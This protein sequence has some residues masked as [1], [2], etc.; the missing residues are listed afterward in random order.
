MPVRGV[1]L[2]VG[3][4]GVVSRAGGRAGGGLFDPDKAG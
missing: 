1:Y 4:R 3:L 2:R